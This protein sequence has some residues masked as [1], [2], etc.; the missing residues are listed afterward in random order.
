MGGS[1]PTQA[2]PVGELAEPLLPL[3]FVSSCLSPFTTWNSRRMG[4]CLL[5]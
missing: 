2:W 4:S 1:R 5:F 3:A